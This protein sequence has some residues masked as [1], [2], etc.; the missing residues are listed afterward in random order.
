MAIGFDFDTGFVEVPL[1]EL[2]NGSV[3][4]IVA[5]PNPGGTQGG[6]LDGVSC[7]SVSHCIAVGTYFDA[8]AIALTLVESWNGSRWSVVASPN[9]S[10]SPK[11]NLYGISCATAVRCLAVGHSYSPSAAAKDATLVESWDGSSWS[12]VTSPSPSTTSV[13]DAVSCVATG[14][15]LAAGLFFNS[16]GDY[17][18]L[19]ESW[20]GSSLSIVNQDA[21]LPGVSCVSA[22]YCVAVGSEISPES[23]STTLIE[24]WN[25]HAWRAVRSPDP[26]QSEGSYLNAITCSSA[27]RCTAVGYYYRTDNSRATLIE[28]WDGVRWSIGRSPNRPGA[29]YSVLLGVTCTD[30]AA[31]PG[32]GICRRTRPC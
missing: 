11:T 18:T 13:L 3:W 30:P 29:A 1:A 4:S 16:S 26:E 17:Q 25:G 27:D 19:A 23:I 7:P 5:T 32:G 28:S 8:D 24:S 2:W 21:D 9:P 12:R 15:C 14:E 31:L 10:G 6:F 22:S 20:T